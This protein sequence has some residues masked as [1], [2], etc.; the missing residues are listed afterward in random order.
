MLGGPYQA[1]LFVAIDRGSAVAERGVAAVSNFD[2][3]E[4]V[5]VTHHE[6]EFTCAGAVVSRD[7]P[8]AATNQI[9]RC[10]TFGAA[11]EP[12]SLCPRFKEQRSVV[13]PVRHGSRR[14]TPGA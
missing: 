6:I 9:A 10:G 14:P 13:R 1:L 5:V 8:H 2:E 7:D 12:R 4:F 3:Y 11:S